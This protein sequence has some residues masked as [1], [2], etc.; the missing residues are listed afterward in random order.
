M[1]HTLDIG[2]H[3][4][5]LS[6]IQCPKEF[7]IQLYSMADKIMTDKVPLEK[8]TYFME[9]VM[10]RWTPEHE[11]HWSYYLPHKHLA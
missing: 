5:I 4:W 1:I 3:L 2:L 8:G 6:T 7:L 10:Q 9:E 11:I